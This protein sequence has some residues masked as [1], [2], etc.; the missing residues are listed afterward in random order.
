MLSK[1]L[2][3]VFIVIAVTLAVL[4]FFKYTHAKD[5][6]MPHQNKLIPLP[7][8]DLQDKDK[9]TDLLKQRRSIRAFKQKAISLD[10]LSKILWAAQGITSSLGYRTAPSAGALYPIEIYIVIGNVTSLEPGLYKY[11][12]NKNALML[13]T[14]GKFRDELAKIAL[15]Q[16]WIKD[17]PVIIIINAILQRTT[18]KYGER[19]IQY[20]HIEVGSVAQNIYL[21]ATHLNLGTTIVG[22]FQDKEL[23][24]LLN[25]NVNEDSFAMMPIGYPNN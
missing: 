13:I 7:E 5:V 24:K 3:F 1:I 19:G 15:N 4:C 9:L 10:E 22:A 12:V 2:V 16:S 8:V 21:Q 25:F 11:D 20:V 23:K 6:I 17:A 14:K 18:Q